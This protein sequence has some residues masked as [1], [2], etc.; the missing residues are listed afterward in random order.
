MTTGQQFPRIL[1]IA[2]W[3]GPLPD[4]F[5]LWLT[6]CRFNPDL[7]WLLAT[8]ANLPAVDIPAN[9]HVVPL[10][11]A[12]FAARIEATVGFSVRFEKAYKACDYRPLYGCLTDL[13]PGNWQFWGHCDM[14][15]L[16]GNIRAFLPLKLL[17]SHDRV[18]G[19]GHFSLYRNDEN[20]NRFYRRPCPGL[21]YREIIADR[22]PR[23]FDEH[24]G[25]NR[26]WHL[27]KGRFYEDESV[28]ADIDPHIGSL[29]RTSSHASAS[30]YRWQIFCFDRGRVLRFY[31]EGGQLRS[32]EFMY[33]HFQKRRFHLPVPPQ[34]CDRVWLTPD[35][36]V[37][38]T[39]EPLTLAKIKEL[40]PSPLLP[41][42][43]EIL[44]RARR[45]VR[46]MR[47]EM[48]RCAK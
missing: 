31:I 21:D 43:V 2:T 15:M 10:T 34:D 36:F 40:N 37:P 7:D 30:N 33:V 14:D 23:G 9:V 12:E 42:I 16:F 32:E 48:S 35:G 18:F 27:H 19:V 29:R 28:I 17:S 45:A 6:S 41:P 8:D 47:H 46:L 1:V 3:F 44:Y 24:I 11:M 25:V 22:Q 26:I 20:A 13:V 5:P 4:W 38:M 39:D